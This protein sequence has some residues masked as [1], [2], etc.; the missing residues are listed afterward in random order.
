MNRDKHKEAL[1]AL[2]VLYNAKAIN[3]DNETMRAA[4]E[5]VEKALQAASWQPIETAPRDGSMFLAY[6][7]RNDSVSYMDTVWFE[8][9]KYSGTGERLQDGTGNFV[10]ATHW[11]PLP[12]APV[13]G[14]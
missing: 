13:G 4:Y 12:A 5:T 8:K 3:T 14:E 9:T 6:C 1:D 11:M 2:V 7:M 10:N